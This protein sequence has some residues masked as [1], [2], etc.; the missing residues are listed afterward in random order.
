MTLIILRILK[1]ISINLDEVSTSMSDTI[2]NFNLLGYI[3]NG[4]FNKIVSKV[5]EDGKYLDISL[6]VDKNSKD[7]EVYSDLP[8][9]LLSNYKFFDGLSG[10]KL[11]LFS[12]YDLNNSNTNLTIENFKVRCSGTCK[13]FILSRFWWNGRCVIWKVV[14]WKIRNV[15]E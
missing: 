10:G 6:R 5:G 14:I 9:Q 2:Y 8:K 11:L 1:D 12:S 7:P 3:D 15:H 4:R 13:T